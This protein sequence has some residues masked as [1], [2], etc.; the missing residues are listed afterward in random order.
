[1]E[2]RR[3]RP[4]KRELVVNDVQRAE[5]ERMGRQSRSARSSLRRGANMPGVST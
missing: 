3:G 2:P 5:L 1:M 4:K